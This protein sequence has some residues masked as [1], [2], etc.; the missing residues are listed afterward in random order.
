MNRHIKQILGQI[1]TISGNNLIAWS[2][3]Y[4]LENE[5]LTND[6]IIGIARQIKEQIHDN[7]TMMKEVLSNEN[8][9]FFDL[10]VL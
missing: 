10:L 4:F 5:E 9:A 8:Y 1:Q 6:A 7:P 2:V 3:N